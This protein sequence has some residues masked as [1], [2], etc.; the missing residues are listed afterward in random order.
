MSHA[1]IEMLSLMNRCVVRGTHST[2]AVDTHDEY[3]KEIGSAF[4]ISDTRYVNDVAR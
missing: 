4:L 1:P 3:G 2:L